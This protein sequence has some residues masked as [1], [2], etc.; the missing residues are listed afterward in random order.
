M[1]TATSKASLGGE[2]TILSA[3][4]AD[5]NAW[6]VPLSTHPACAVRC[7]SAF[8][9]DD[10]RFFE[11]NLYRHP[12]PSSDE[13]D[14]ERAAG[15][16][17][18]PLAEMRRS[19][20][21][22]LGAALAAVLLLT[23]LATPAAA[24]EETSARRASA[25][26]TDVEP[27]ARSTSEG[28]ASAD[29]SDSPS[30]DA[31]PT[32]R[33]GLL[34]SAG[35]PVA[36]PP[37]I[38]LAREDADVT[39]GIVFSLE[40][41]L[42]AASVADPTGALAATRLV[43]VLTA[44]LLCGEPA[45]A[46]NP[47]V[48]CGSLFQVTPDGEKGEEIPLAACAS[49]SAGADSAC[50]VRD[51]KKRVWFAPEPGGRDPSGPSGAA[52]ATVSFV[53]V[54]NAHDAGWPYYASD[55]D[56]RSATA[57]AAVRV[58]AKP[59]VPSAP[60][61]VF[62]DSDFDGVLPLELLASDPDGDAVSIEITG[63][64]P[65]KEPVLG[66][67]LFAQHGGKHSNEG[68]TNAN[69]SEW[70]AVAADGVSPGAGLLSG[71]TLH[72][73][74]PG[75][76]RVWFAPRGVGASDACCPA[77]ACG[78][79]QVEATCEPCYD[80]GDAT[81]DAGAVKPEND[82]LCCAARHFYGRLT[83]VARDAL[84][85][86]SNVE[87]VVDVYVRPGSRAPETPPDDDAR[88]K[89][90]HWAPPRVFATEGRAAYFRLAA[91]NFG[92]ESCVEVKTNVTA[93]YVSCAPEPLGAVLLDA[94]AEGS[95]EE[96]EKGS[97]R[98]VVFP[99]DLAELDDAFGDGG[100]ARRVVERFDKDRVVFANGA[101]NETDAFSSVAFSESFAGYE[102]EVDDA[103]VH[104]IVSEALR[105][106]VAVLADLE[107]YDVAAMGALPSSWTSSLGNPVMNARVVPHEARLLLAYTPPAVAAGFPLA[108]FAYG[109]SDGAGLLSATTTL[110]RFFVRHALD[111]DASRFT[112]FPHWAFRP[113]SPADWVGVRAEDTVNWWVSGFET[114][115]DA[116][117]RS[118][119]FLVP[120]K[121]GEMGAFVYPFGRNDIGQLGMGSARP[122]RFPTLAD[123]VRHRGLDLDRLAVGS[124]S[125]IGISNSDGKAY[126]WGDGAGGRLGTGDAF[127]R[128]SPTAVGAL[129]DAVVARVAAGGGH[130]AAVTEDGHLWCWGT[131]DGGQLGR[132]RRTGRLRGPAA[133]SVDPVAAAAAEPRAPRRVTAGGLDRVLVRDVA[134]G[135]AHTV[136]LDASGTLWTF[137]SN[138][139]GQLG[140][141]ECL[142]QNPADGAAGCETWGAPAYG[143][144][145]TPG[146]VGLVLRHRKD[147]PGAET[148]G[149]RL[150]DADLA[151][152]VKF[153][154][155]AANARYTVAVSDGPPPGSREE[156]A[157]A[158]HDG[159]SSGV[160][161][162]GVPDAER[163]R[164]PAFPRNA[165]AL[166]QAAFDAVAHAIGGRVYTFGWGDVGQLGHGLGFHP[167]A[168]DAYRASVPTP[169]A[170]LEGVD[171]VQVSAGPTHVAAVDR[172]GRVYTWGAGSYGQLGHGD[173]RPAFAPRLVRALLGVNITSVAA[174]TR[175]TVAV[176]DA[177]E[178]YAWGSNEHG[179][180]GLDPPPPL[181]PNKG[182][183]YLTLRGWTQDEIEDDSTAA[184]R[185]RRRRR[186]LLRIDTEDD[187][188]GEHD[189]IF[190][191]LRATPDGTGD[192]AHSHATFRALI[193]GVEPTTPPPWSDAYRFAEVAAS[194]FDLDSIRNRAY[195]WGWTVGQVTASAGRVESVAL[196]QLVHRLA[197][198]SEAA[199]GDGFTVAV[200]RACRPG[201]RLDRTTGACVTCP[202]GT[203]ADAAS[204]ETC[205]VC[206]RGR[207]AKFPGASVCEACAP[208]TV[209]AEEGASVCAACPPGTFLGFGGGSSLEQCAPCAPGTFASQ[210]ATVV[211]TPC[212]PGS[213]QNAFGAT[214]CSSCP[215]STFSPKKKAV[216]SE[217]CLRCPAGSFSNAEGVAACAPCAPG[218]VAPEPGMTAC[219][220]CAVGTYAE[221]ENGQK[222]AP[223][224]AGTFG[225]ATNASSAEIGCRPCGAGNFS[226]AL[227]A[228]ACAP[229]PLGFFSTAEGSVEC[230]PC[231]PGFFGKFEG[232]TSRDEACFGCVPGRANPT[233]GAAATVT[234]VEDEDAASSGGE[235]SGGGDASANAN[236]TSSETPSDDDVEYSYVGCVACAPGTYAELA[237]ATECTP[238]PP[239]TYLGSEGATSAESC[240]KCAVGTFSPVSGLDACLPCPPGTFAES[241]GATKCE[242][243]PAGLFNDVFGSFNATG[244]EACPP[245]SFSD[246]A[247]TGNCTACFPGTY[248]QAYASPA[249]DLCPAGTFL[250]RRN[251]TD[252]SQCE[253]CPTGTFAENEGTGECSPCPPGSFNDVTGMG[254]C[255]ACPPGTA[256]PLFGGNETSACVPCAIGTVAP[257]AG[258]AVCSPCAEGTYVEEEGQ[259]ECV[260]CPAGSY[261]PFT[262]SS[263]VENCLPCPT[264]PLGTFAAAPGAAVCAPCPVGTYSDEVGAERC[265][266]TPKGTYL[267]DVGANSSDA[268]R[269]CPKGTFAPTEGMEECLDCLTGSYAENEGSVG[270]TPCDAGYFLPIIRADD[271]KQCRP[272]G[273]GTR[274]PPGAGS[275]I[276][277]PPGYYGDQEAMAECT[278][279][280]AGTVNAVAGASSFDACVECGK[281]F[282]NAFDGRALCLPCPPG[283]YGN[284]TGMPECWKCAPGSFISEEGA[285]FPEDC[286]PCAK[287]RFAESAG[288][289]VC[290]LCPVG[291]YNENLGMSR[292]ELCPARTY[293]L[294]EGADSLL[295]CDACPR[296]H[297]NS[298]PG[299]SKIQ[300]CV[301]TFSGARGTSAPLFWMF[302]VAALVALAR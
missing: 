195:G 47:I 29:A 1:T 271:P 259:T 69:Q 252:P 139:G 141:L 159:A 241:T 170:A 285:L 23:A 140:R 75:S 33:R 231:P 82:C 68:E 34:Q 120:K 91:R 20:R 64:L 48:T 232:M 201:T 118:T 127:P 78:G 240:K 70:R 238:C 66:T 4:I 194:D 145:E 292:C 205:V 198:V 67:R 76:T 301:Y 148:A 138:S 172:A 223:C 248:S 229:C 219:V 37:S 196:P 57:V 239:G 153:R 11:R 61:K 56:R 254:N 187:P 281:G 13:A 265:S 114:I 224:P 293:G 40:G 278:A 102:P 151:I 275:C 294:E 62:V 296:W 298:A 214:E 21:A 46:A 92:E 58:N 52:Y 272:C 60:R 124:S 89:N 168:P 277:C 28:A 191:R 227:G 286:E 180:L 72:A 43:A 207:V 117:L 18:V 88:E 179:E 290:D 162:G 53:V 251:A 30:P 110:V 184:G 262:G 125:T 273:L 199:A 177:G 212:P 174:G 302:A 19:G 300:S 243:C 105:L 10:V 63:A 31:S 236:A 202:A 189:L 121:M 260:P 137:G 103:R 9:F 142:I 100:F 183:P 27:G 263:W 166:G 149:T 134:V 185:K 59:V 175:H 247:G 237:N 131:N 283:T 123:D 39:R 264:S 197:Q 204:S 51:A 49:S 144:L 116:R 15:C 249:C 266:P 282:H 216:S 113:I 80:D 190:E 54:D 234:V 268:S 160:K 99:E 178:V 299:S 74:T 26:T 133:V 157:L 150:R 226:S 107:P 25:P 5:W 6:T 108:A 79:M 86:R 163:P 17:P 176:D 269:P 42:D 181:D 256:N 257:D 119:N 253:P 36:T 193:A 245:G 71:S 152:G 213:F 98:A 258:T 291:T 211:C 279:C 246:V 96:A 165:T 188:A 16:G 218:F 209:A 203:F 280:P 222:C 244:C 164:D 32:T 128:T 284:Q 84:G 276:P 143:V 81:I 126:A 235:S 270:C 230:E 206:P 41:A 94:P 154:F 135:D 87:G 129:G 3:E 95:T 24:P 93:P 287:G 167:D 267:P 192:V 210:N 44:P 169:V 12:G 45:T 242:G 228:A 65:G 85:S 14:G 171:V 83:Y 132:P 73:L 208:G 112:R 221:G 225:V 161:V 111:L 233:S 215:S 173:R 289:G 38:R 274:S 109:V 217:A 250:N 295:R 146:A 220:P 261:L 106:G 7:F 158:A 155:I 297:F 22:G 97:L 2:R 55:A 182:P 90:A 130:A 255:T 122:R 136:A 8:A 50:A 186:A 200:R 288:S 156:A 115:P 147:R 104:A 35:R 101:S 77:R